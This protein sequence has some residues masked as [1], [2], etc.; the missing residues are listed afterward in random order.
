[1]SNDGYLYSVPKATDEGE[2]GDEEYKDIVKKRYVSSNDVKRISKK[3]SKSSIKS[4]VSV[5]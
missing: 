4:N 2:I 1:M 5:Q 3:S